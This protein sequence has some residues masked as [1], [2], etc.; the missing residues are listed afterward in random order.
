MSSRS[1]LLD[2]RLPTAVYDGQLISLLL[3]LHSIEACQLLLNTREQAHYIPVWT[4]TLMLVR[5]PLCYNHSIHICHYLQY[6]QA[7]LLAPSNYLHS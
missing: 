7:H 6:V 1:Q 3:R 2:E 5:R 4:V